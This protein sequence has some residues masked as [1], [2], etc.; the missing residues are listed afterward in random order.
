MRQS[1]NYIN[2]YTKSCKRLQKV[3]TN[4]AENNQ[5]Q[6]VLSYNSSSIATNGQQLDV[7]SA[8]Q[9]LIKFIHPYIIKIFSK[10]QNVKW[11]Y[12]LL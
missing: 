10:S 8:W 4:M 12:W 5:K 9:S 3:Y 7:T 6:M 11:C 2:M 1:C